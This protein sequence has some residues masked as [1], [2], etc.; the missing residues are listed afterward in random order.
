MFIKVETLTMQIQIRYTTNNRNEKT[1]LIGTINLQ[2]FKQFDN[3]N[4]AQRQQANN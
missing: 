4:W 1:Q 2:Q 3:Y